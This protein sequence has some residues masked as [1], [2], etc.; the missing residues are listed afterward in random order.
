MVDVVFEIKIVFLIVKKAIVYEFDVLLTQE[1]KPNGLG[2]LSH[3]VRAML[4]TVNL[5]PE[6]GMMETL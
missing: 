5:R 1:N 2:T 4:E 6:D 3:F